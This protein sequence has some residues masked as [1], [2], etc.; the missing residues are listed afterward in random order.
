MLSFIAGDGSEE[1]KAIDLDK[2]ETVTL[3]GASGEF[4]GCR[5]DAAVLEG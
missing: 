3:P 5:L 2:T 1:T 4:T